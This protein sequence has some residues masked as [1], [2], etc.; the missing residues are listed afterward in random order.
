MQN[1]TLTIESLTVEDLKN[2]S[3]KELNQ[4][5]VVSYREGR[6]FKNNDVLPGVLRLKLALVNRAA[7]KSI[8]NGWMIAH[9][10]E[11]VKTSKGETLVH[12]VF[13]KQLEEIC[14]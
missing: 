13:Q 11:P 3:I 5:G 6:T 8:E 9:L 14:S 4:L 10:A 2:K 12:S 7:L 1:T